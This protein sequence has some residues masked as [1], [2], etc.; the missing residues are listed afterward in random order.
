MYEQIEQPYSRTQPIG[1]RILGQVPTHQSKSETCQEIEWNSARRELQGALH[2][3][4]HHKEHVKQ[5]KPQN[6]TVQSL[7]AATALPKRVDKSFHQAEM[8]RYPNSESNCSQPRQ[9]G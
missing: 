9:D 8:K 5:K 4:S 3:T 7:I 6:E 2:K 1:V